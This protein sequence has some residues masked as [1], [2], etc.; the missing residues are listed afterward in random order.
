MFNLV[1]TLL[2]SALQA[3]MEPAK[4]IHALYEMDPKLFEMDTVRSI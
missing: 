4:K 2:C 3:F 1:F